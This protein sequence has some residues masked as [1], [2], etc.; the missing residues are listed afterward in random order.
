M[1]NPPPRRSRKKRIDE[2]EKDRESISRQNA[3][4]RTSSF[5]REEGKD[6][7]RFIYS[8]GRGE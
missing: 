7:F 5:P 8:G 2:R 3:E 4:D 1:C 6:A